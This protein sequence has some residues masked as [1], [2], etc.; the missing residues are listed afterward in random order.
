MN[1]DLIHYTMLVMAAS[2]AMRTW[3]DFKKNHKKEFIVLG[4]FW[5]FIFIF[6]VTRLIIKEVT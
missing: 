2:I 4:V 6:I 1:S 3:L 5:V